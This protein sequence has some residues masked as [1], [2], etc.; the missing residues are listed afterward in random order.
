MVDKKAI[1]LNKL[2]FQNESGVSAEMNFNQFFLTNA[3][4]ATEPL[5]LT[6]GFYRYTNAD[7]TPDSKQS[8]FQVMLTL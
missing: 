6:K 5:L 2:N 8:F 1:V 7:F 3:A 4:K